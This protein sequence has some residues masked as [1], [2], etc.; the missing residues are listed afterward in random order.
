MGVFKM[1]NLVVRAAIGAVAFVGVSS[2]DTTKPVEQPGKASANFVDYVTA[3]QDP[4]DPFTFTK[5]ASSKYRPGSVFLIAT[6]PEGGKRR[7]LRG[8]FY[9]I[10]APG[11]KYTAW[12]SMDKMPKLSSAKG[13]DDTSLNLKASI[14]AFKPSASINLANKMDINVEEMVDIEL[15]G[16]AIDKKRREDA[17][18]NTCLEGLTK[19]PEAYMIQQGIGIKK[20]TFTFKGDSGA[21]L[22][23]PEAEISKVVQ[24]GGGAKIK[25]N[26][27]GTLTYEADPD[28]PET[29]IM[30]AYKTVIK[31]EGGLVLGG[32]TVPKNEA[33]NA[34]SVPDT[35]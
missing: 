29:I 20:A 9:D 3:G 16:G 22:T 30:V 25:W 1:K 15:L 17:A 18:F 21:E 8:T 27:H 13:L 6:T 11:T 12:V 14:G 34:L 7:Q 31:T 24:A 28:K 19:Q 32:P 4:G 23:L 10:C 26:N 2:C 5:P 35:P 33:K